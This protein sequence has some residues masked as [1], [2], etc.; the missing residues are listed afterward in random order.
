MARAY[1]NI[2]RVLKTHGSKGEVVVAP[3]RG[4]PFAMYEGMEVA[5]TPPALDRDRFV[6]VEGIAGYEDAPRVRF[7][8]ASSLEDAE[9]LV[10]CY[11]LADVD[12]LDLAPL[13]VAYDDLIGRSVLDERFGDLGRIAEVMETPAND[14]WV[15]RGSSHGEV[16]IP[17][18]EDVVLDLPASGPISVAVM[19]GLI[20]S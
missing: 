20:N 2:A 19:D 7:G 14:V 18:I 15:L 5:L 1:K 9:S 10:G 8:C 17:V 4:L 3:L 11:V 13:D 16:L 6:T 12:D